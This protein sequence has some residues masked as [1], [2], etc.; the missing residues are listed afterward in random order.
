MGKRIL[1][2][3][4]GGTDP[5][6]EKNIQ[7]GS[8]LHICRYYYP[9][10][11]VLY[12]SKE[13]LERHNK[14][15]RYVYCINRL[16]KLQRRKIKVS[17]IERPELENVQEF[18]FFYN[19]FR[20]CLY[21]IMGRMSEDDELLINVSSGT[22]A[23]KSGLLVLVTFAE[24]PCKA[25]QVYTPERA[26]QEHIH[27]EYDN[28]MMWEM[29]ED[30]TNG[31]N[32]C[33]EVSLPT[34]N[35]MK[36]DEVIIK[37]VMAYDY[38]A[39]FRIATALP[40]EH[41]KKYLSLL[42]LAKAR[43]SL[44]EKEVGR[45]SPNNRDKIFPF[46]STNERRVFEYALSLDIKRRRGEYADFMRAFTPL[47]VRLTELI[48]FK[49]GN[50][51]VDDLTYT[52]RDG[53]VCWNEIKLRETGIKAVMDDWYA[54]KGGFLGKNV[55]S[56]HI[57]ALISAYVKDEGII[58]TVK[59]LRDVET[60]IRNKAAHTMIAIS[61]EMIME[62]TNKSSAQIM[63]LI[64]KAFSYTGIHADREDWNSY[65]KMNSMII[66]RIQPY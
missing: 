6:A 24:F 61:D 50:I 10:E 62:K 60:H 12:L 27:R 39:A 31:I 59:N 40:E 7:D 51:N 36:N 52:T 4:I 14:D 41:T 53:R 34:L 1:F 11:V 17:L 5:I 26:M 9:D 44:D 48:L 49:K 56:D 58:N 37:H 55:S 28:E 65:D 2:S 8:M 16:E 57:V 64:K 18:D 3:P 38:D 42:A 25:I 66:G 30:N 21:D 20:N 15:N 19:E 45:I 22:P 32:R 43:L 63:E 13:I 23:M 33:T 54:N 46:W 29:N 47:F 35:L